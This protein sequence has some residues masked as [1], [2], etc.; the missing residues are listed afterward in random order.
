MWAFP[1]I[2][3]CSVFHHRSSTN[4]RDSRPHSVDWRPRVLGSRFRLQGLRGTRPSDA[5]RLDVYRHDRGIC[6]LPLH[7]AHW[8]YAP[9][10]RAFIWDLENSQPTRM[11]VVCIGSGSGG[12]YSDS[13]RAQL[14]LLAQLAIPNSQSGDCIHRHD[15]NVPSTV[16]LLWT[17]QRAGN[18]RIFS[19]IRTRLNYKHRIP[20]PPQGFRAYHN[21]RIY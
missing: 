13:C 9:T 10:A 7:D 3:R 2:V 8:A 16:Q 12:A 19:G 5:S 11:D 21:D 14:Q 18:T 15:C 6:Y 20:P 17:Q 1:F 4:I